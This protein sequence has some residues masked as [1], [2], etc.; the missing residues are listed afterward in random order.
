MKLPN[1]FRALAIS[2]TENMVNPEPGHVILPGDDVL[3]Y[4]STGN[5]LRKAV[6]VF[7]GKPPS[8]S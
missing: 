6:D 1:G 5:N 7:A 2:H 8:R 3:L 4:S